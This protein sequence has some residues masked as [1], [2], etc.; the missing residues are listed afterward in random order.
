MNRTRVLIMGAAGRDFHNFNVIYRND[1]QSKVVAFTATQIPNIEGRLYPP[2][3]SG[4]LYPDGI[5]ILD[6]VDL[7]RLISEFKVDDVVFAYSDVS[8]EYVMHKASE[9]LKCGSNFKLLGGEK[10]MIKSNKLV[11]AIG[12]VRTGSGKSQTTRRVAEVLTNAGISVAVIRHPMPYGDLKKQK[13]QRFA[14]IEDLKNYDCTIEEMEEYE[15]HID[16]GSVV[17]AGVDYKAILDKAEKEADIILWDGGNNDM[18]F[19]KPDLFLVVVDPHRPGH[20]LLFYPGESN[21]LMADVV[22]INKMDTAEPENIATV[23][24]NIA[25]VNPGATIIEAASPVT[26]EKPDVIKGKRCLVVED[27]PTLTHGG[28]K[29]GAGIVAAEKFGA[30]EVVDPRPWITGTIAETFES[31]P[32]IGKLLPAMGYGEQQIKDLEATINAADCDVVIIGT[33]IDLRR[34]LHIEKPSVR[35]TYNLKETG[36]PT[37]AN[38]LEPF[39]K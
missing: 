38:V 18:P 5:P 13:V 36:R 10:T 8:H 33:P 20:E 22:V 4:E 3:L 9:V 34:L 16:R 14:T 6:E 28:M 26:V 30:T 15:P 39:T 11:I 32:D 27:G 7:S 2:E 23:K 12:A 37:V 35:V 29:F 25:S 19:Y 17:F 21:L 24:A 1:P 31:Y